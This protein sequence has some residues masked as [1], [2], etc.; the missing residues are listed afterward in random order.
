ML[1]ACE[2]AARLDFDIEEGTREGIRRCGEEVLRAAPPRL[3]EELL[4]LLRCGAAARA[5]DW[6]LELG[7]LD[8]LLPEAHAMVRARREGAGDFSGILP[9]LDELTAEGRELPDEVLLASVILPTLLLQRFERERQIGEWM[10]VG[11]FRKLVADTLAAFE[12]RFAVPNA[13]RA[14]M[15]QAFDGFHRMAG[16][17]WTPVQRRRLAEKSYFDHAFG[18][19]EVLVRATG[20]GGAALAEWQEARAERPRDAPRVERDGGSSRGRSRRRRRRRGGRGGR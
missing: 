6:M 7:L 15:E 13:K 19:F 2:F 12:E 8:I 4:Q 9:A 10:P 14:R 18:V 5:V 16:R 3:T 11:A 1:R 20:Q 17:R